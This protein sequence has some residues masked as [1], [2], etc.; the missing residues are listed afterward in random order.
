MLFPG[1]T[2]P[3]FTLS[4]YILCLYFFVYGVVFSRKKYQALN[5]ENVFTIFKIA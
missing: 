3:T 5:T 1:L 2:L 4:K